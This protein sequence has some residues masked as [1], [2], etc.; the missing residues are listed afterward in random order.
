MMLGSRTLILACISA[1][2]LPASAFQIVRVVQPGAAA[3]IQTAVD[4]A[5]DGD[6]VLVH[7]GT[8]GSVRV[9]NKSL[10][11]VAD[12]AGSVT[13]N[14]LTIDTMSAA[15]TCSV[16]GLRMTGYEMPERA[17][18]RVIACDG[19]VF[20]EDVIAQ[21]TFQTAAHAAFVTASSAVTF[22]HCTL[23]GG[24]QQMP[25]VVVPDPP[26]RG[27]KIATSRVAAYG[28]TIR[29]AAGR[30]TYIMLGAGFMGAAGAP[31]VQITDAASI[32]VASGSSITGGNGGSGAHGSCSPMYSPTTGFDGAAGVVA[33]GTT[34]LRDDVV[35]GGAGGFGGACMWCPPLPQPAPGCAAANGVAGAQLT[36]NPAVLAIPRVDVEIP[37]H[38][39]ESTSLPITVR[40]AAGSVAFLAVSTTT[41]WDYAP[42]LAGTL[43]YGT[44]TRRLMLGTIPSGG[45]T[46]SLPI[47]ALAPGVEM[48][49]NF[50]QVFAR[51]AAGMVTAGTP[52]ALVILDQAF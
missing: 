15:R 44:P 21:P 30:S 49:R 43:H 52:V 27:L 29:G 51:D 32:F 31:G 13:V 1:L 40:G 2:S 8:Y 23:E 5:S 25:L 16:S 36:G 37:T 48:K 35:T 18:I 6:V 26:G 33:A 45:L 28:C 9:T 3:A 22:T 34:V 47:P 17:A 19:P 10:S 4:A 20:L 38:V 41:R 12:P 11:L 50:I 46:T 39:R 14:S 24:T 42:M 7:A